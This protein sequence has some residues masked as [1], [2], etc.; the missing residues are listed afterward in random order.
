MALFGRFWDRVAPLTKAVRADPMLSA[1]VDE[2][3]AQRIVADGPGLALAAMR[4]GAI[5]HA[6]GYGLADLQ[7]GTPCTPDSIFHLA[8]CGKQFTGLGL[9]MLA[10]PAFLL[11]QPYRTLFKEPQR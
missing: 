3:I 1:Q 11:R 7:A 8:S 4:S 2:E 6:A 10:V 5:V 9:L